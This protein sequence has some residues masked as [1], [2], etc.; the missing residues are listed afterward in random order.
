MFNSLKSK[1]IIPGVGITMIVVVCIMGF[2]LYSST[3]LVDNFFDERMSAATSAVR[4]YLQAYEQ[5]TF[6]T[7][8][9][10]GSSAELIRR[11]HAGNREAIW[12]YTA[13]RQAFFGV[14]AII[15]ADHQGITLARSHIRDS[16][17][18]NVTGVPSIAAGLRGE[19]LT[20]Y[21]PTPTAPMVMTTSSPVL[22]GDT[23]I[24]SVVV[25]F[26]VGMNEF[27]DELKN[28]FNIDATVFVGN[29]SVS[30]TL[31]HPVTGQRAIGT[32]AAEEITEAVL[33]RGEHLPIDL[34]IFG[35][36]P[37][38][39]YYFPLPGADG[40]PIGMF[41]IGISKEHSANIIGGLL[42]NLI[43]IGIFSLVI[44]SIGM[45]LHI[46]RL[47]TPVGTL[48]N[49]LSD[50]ASGDITKRLPEAGNDELSKASRSYNESMESFKAMISAIKAQSRN[51]SEIGNNLATNM[52]QTASA[53]NQIAANIQNI[54]S[55]VMNQS[56]SVTETN[57]TMEQVSTGIG[58][59]NTQVDSQAS[60]VSQSASAIEEMIAN[61]Q[62]V[63]T[64]LAKNAASVEELQESSDT[65]RAS[66]QE[67][68]SDIQEIAKESEGLLE[69]NAVMENIASQTNLLSM[70]AAIEAAHA[71]DAGKG[72]AVV[73]AE[74]RKLAESS[75]EQS[76]TIGN[77]LK[78]I[79]L[80]IDKISKSTSNVMNKFE[81]IDQ[82]VRIVSQQEE[83]IRNAME[84]Q[85]AGSKQIL[86]ASEQ[87]NDIT[88]QVKS[89][90]VRMLEGSKEVIQESQDLERV[91][92]EI[93][94][95]MNEM[96]M[97]AEQVNKAVAAVNDLSN[98]TKENISELVQV[99]SKFKV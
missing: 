88:Q 91:T 48:S 37:F 47:L 56:A 7:A 66:L 54:K 73:A 24:G 23:I 97:G 80:S 74:I 3:R 44:I 19:N 20:L 68:A 94:N 9:A 25:N 30:S 92:Q 2:V 14:D 46:G 90:S 12:E 59:L 40:N 64:T 5:K 70:N 89:G 77:V 15:V 58:K 17:G 32:A 85:N 28:T 83:N 27:L 31:I 65:G 84:E 6:M 22:D 52:T 72:F 69:I 57:S 39:A 10:M 98:R 53:M 45:F 87:V 96:A 62:S 33:Q 60:A 61:I 79:K 81:L 1:I 29:T 16:F 8:S 41:F 95:G 86:Q 63:T 42:R 71:G 11:I 49:A 34:D 21:T 93:N 67:V 43:I 35:M 38:S 4:A 55:R 82:S 78:K 13:E 18:D 76:K 36:L 26:D 51:L 99:V 75:G 50:L